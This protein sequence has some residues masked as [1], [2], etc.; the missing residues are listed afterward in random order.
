MMT[1]LQLLLG[2]TLAGVAAFSSLV[3]AALVHRLVRTDV[4]GLNLA[5]L[6]AVWVGVA[7]ALALVAGLLGVLT[8]VGLA[9]LSAG[10]VGLVVLAP[11]GRAELGELPADAKRAWLQGRGWWAQLPRFLRLAGVVVAA[12][13]AARFVFLIWTFPPFVW[14]ALTYHLTNVAA[15]TQAGRLVVVD[16]PVTRTYLPANFEVLTTWFTV[17]LHHDLF[18]EAAGIPGYLIACVAVYSIARRLGCAA[19]TALVASL[20]YAT[21]PALL[22]AASG[23]KN[24]PLMT[25]IILLLAALIIDLILRPT[26]S[27]ERNRSGQMALVLGL[28]LYGLGTKA[29]LLHVSV[30]LVFVAVALPWAAGNPGAWRQA[31]REAKSELN[32]GGTRRKAAL[33]AFLATS[34]LLGLYWYARNLALTGNPFYPMGVEMGTATVIAGVHNNFPISLARLAENLASFWTK[35]GD[36]SGPIVPDLP[37]TTGWGWLAYGIGLPTMVWALVRLRIVRVVVIGFIVSM[38]VLFLSA[39]ASPW[40]MRYATWFPAMLCL[41]TACFLQAL[42]SELRGERRALGALLVLGATLNVLPTLVYGRIPLDEFKRMLAKPALERSAAGL[43]LTIGDTYEFAVATVPDDEVLG[44]HVSSNGFIYPLYGAD[45]SQ[46]V[47]YIPFGPTTPCPQLV[48]AVQEA[49]TRWLFLGYTSWR[50]VDRVRACA[51]DGFFTFRGEN[52]YELNAPPTQP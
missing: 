5:A 18:I 17:F 23:T 34:L 49:G 46:P 31:F 6:G 13:L 45:L 42:P 27:P 19:P 24:D 29:Y 40:N 20:A 32:Q 35:F 15:W 47:A 39:R 12:I 16:S 28:G 52:L 36:R 3:L 11:H 7:T 22:L 4:A 30:G 26:G 44:Y 9:G 1:S 50:D 10:L 41:T 21:T 51:Q 38:A 33:A 8:G 43:Y 25:G 14:D 48:E 37:N 2:I